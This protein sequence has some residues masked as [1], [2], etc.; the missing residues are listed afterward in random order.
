[1]RKFIGLKQSSLSK[2]SFLKNIPK[3]SNV[4][5]QIL[6]GKNEAIGSAKINKLD[7]YLQDVEK[8]AILTK[9]EF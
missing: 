7:V 3:N 6:Y 9:K 4:W 5:R 2:Y 8:L 1:M